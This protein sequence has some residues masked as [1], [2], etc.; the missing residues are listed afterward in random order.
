MASR[1]QIICLCEGQKGS[2]VDAVFIN[3]LIKSLRPDWLR[4][5]GSNVIRQVSCG[6][7][8][9]VMEKMPAELK[10]C[11]AAGGHTT[12]MV[13]ADCDDDCADPEVLK[14]RFWAEAQRQSVSRKDFDKVVFCL[15]K[16][17][18]ENW[19]EFLNSGATDESIEGP[20][21]KHNREAAEAAKKL[22]VVCKVGKADQKMPQSLQWSCKHWQAL[23][24]RMKKA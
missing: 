18:I 2:S 16:D 4:P 20:R 12:L 9:E 5:W 10:T 15:A 14:Q 17:R 13:W 8:K 24:D 19:I 21:V 23:K 11:L 3:R 1:T 22:A 7:R 6:G